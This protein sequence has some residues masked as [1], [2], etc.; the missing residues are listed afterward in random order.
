MEDFKFEGATLIKQGNKIQDTVKIFEK[1]EVV[2]PNSSQGKQ[3][4]VK[5][6]TKGKKTAHVVRNQNLNDKLLTLV[7]KLDKK[8]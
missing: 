5:R 7:G 1:D 3:V 6:L 8:L 4:T 2:K